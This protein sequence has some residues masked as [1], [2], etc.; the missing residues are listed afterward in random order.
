MKLLDSFDNIHE[1]N[2][3]QTTE[4]PYKILFKNIT[5][6]TKALDMLYNMQTIY[7]S[8]NKVLY[9]GPLDHH[10]NLNVILL[11]LLPTRYYIGT[12][13]VRQIVLNC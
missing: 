9:P 6:K 12:K 10:Q 7:Q 1:E 8:H 13:T 2:I 11:A 4:D 3:Y 5:A